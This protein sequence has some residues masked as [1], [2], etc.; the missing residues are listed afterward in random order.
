MNITQAGLSTVQQAQ[1]K[2]DQ[3]ATNLAQAGGGVTVEDVV[4]L[5]EAENQALVG[6]KILKAASSMH[7]G[8]IDTFA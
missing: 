3:H 7:K 8:L 6:A 2:A 4:G 1:A 5:R